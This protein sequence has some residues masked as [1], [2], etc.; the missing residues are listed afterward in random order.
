MKM[1]R[2]GIEKMEVMEKELFLTLHPRGAW[3]SERLLAAVQK[4][5]G[6]LR[7][8]GEGKLALPLPSGVAP[9]DTLDTVLNQLSSLV[10]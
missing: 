2:L 6:W 4:K 9:L 5:K 1:K 7:F 3:S 10:S 8:K